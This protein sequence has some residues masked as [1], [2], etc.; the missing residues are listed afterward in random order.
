MS[1]EYIKSYENKDHND[2]EKP[3][4]NINHLLTNV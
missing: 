1:K 4:L 2:K 3:C